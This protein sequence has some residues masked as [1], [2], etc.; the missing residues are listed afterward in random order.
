ML[1]EKKFSEPG[2]ISLGNKPVDVAATGT[3]RA[4]DG[5]VDPFPVQERK[6]RCVELDVMLPKNPVAADNAADLAPLDDYGAGL[7]GGIRIPSQMA[8]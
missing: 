8:R 3:H 1:L 2:S 5:L 7:A 4:L 6:Q